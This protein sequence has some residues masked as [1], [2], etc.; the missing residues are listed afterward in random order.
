MKYSTKFKY[1][2]KVKILGTGL[3][4]ELIDIVPLG[5]SPQGVV[6]KYKVF[7]I[8]KGVLLVPENALEKIENED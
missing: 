4:G 5:I 6:Y 1:N 3:E 2:D 7:T 8:T